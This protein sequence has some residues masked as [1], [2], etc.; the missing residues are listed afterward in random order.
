MKRWLII[1]TVFSWV[2]CISAQENSREKKVKG[3]YTYEIPKSMSYDQ[4]CQTALVKA[5][6]DAIAEAFG[7]SMMEDNNLFVSNINGQSDVSFHSTSEG[8]IRGVWLADE[9]E[10]V[11][12]KF[13][14]NGR[15]WVK[16]TVK[17]RAR[18]IRSAGIDFEIAPI[19]YKPD[20]ELATDV[21]K[22]NDDFFLYFKSPVNGYL[23]IFLFDI[24]ANQAYCMLP[25]QD[26]GSGSYPITFGQDYYFFSPN[27]YGK[28]LSK[29][30]QQQRDDGLVIPSSLDYKDFNKWLMKC[31][32]KDEE[33][34]VRRIPIKII[35]K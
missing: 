22:N 29:N 12:E 9:S 23:T 11:Y 7:L 34:E 1:L 21:F 18:E 26:S 28:V 6:N 10:P 15:D 24:A 27:K 20:K 3:S 16:V 2:L 13:Q 25:Y 8:K 14:E 31:Q 5:Q 30:S 32:Q 33:M 35:N 4:A 19:R 17:G